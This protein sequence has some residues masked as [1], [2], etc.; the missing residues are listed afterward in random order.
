MLAASLQERDRHLQHLRWRETRHQVR[1]Q[2]CVLVDCDEVG[3]WLATPEPS[4][5]SPLMSKRS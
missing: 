5:T 4:L 2:L 3:G 1:Q